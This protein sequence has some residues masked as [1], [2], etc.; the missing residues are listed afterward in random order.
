MTLKIPPQLEQALEAR[1]R[2]RHMTLE[3]AVRE[4]LVCYLQL[5]VDTLDE[6]AAWQE[7]RD[8]ALGKVE[9]S[10]P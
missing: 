1:A 9:E 2:Q 8:E 7:V 10:S 3:E 5:D 4:A 6:L